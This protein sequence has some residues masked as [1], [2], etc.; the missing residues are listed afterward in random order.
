MRIR[1]LPRPVPRH[2][3]TTATEAGVLPL[4]SLVLA[5]PG[6]QAGLGLIGWMPN[7]SQFAHRG[8]HGSHR[9]S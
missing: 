3:N 5:L 8:V 2:Q 4:M 1:R 7:R 9:T 6:N